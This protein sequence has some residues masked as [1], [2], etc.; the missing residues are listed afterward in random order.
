MPSELGGIKFTKKERTT[1]IQET[2]TLKSVTVEEC[3]LLFHPT[4]SK[5]SHSYHFFKTHTDL[6]YIPLSPSLPDHSITVT[7]RVLVR[8]KTWIIEA[9]EDT[10][11]TT[12]PEESHVIKCQNS[13]K[14]RH[15]SNKWNL[16]SAS[17]ALKR[18]EFPSLSI[19]ESEAHTPTDASG[20]PLATR[21]ERPS[22][23][24][25]PY[26]E[27]SSFRKILQQPTV[28][29]FLREQCFIKEWG[30]ICHILHL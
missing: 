2:L 23:F 26:I 18:T 30:K 22:A 19:P 11:K 10:I 14:H 4:F 21:M 24:F 12:L 9:K 7:S 16:P 27:M 17:I 5:S 3:P 29:R 8:L 25:A 28:L 1:G 13:M 6:V 20:R 15:T